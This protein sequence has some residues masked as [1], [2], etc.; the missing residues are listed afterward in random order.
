MAWKQWV[1]LDRDGKWLTHITGDERPDDKKYLGPVGIKVKFRSDI[2]AT[3]KTTVELKRGEPYS[4]RELSRNNRFRGDNMRAQSALKGTNEVSI[5]EMIALP[6]A[7]G[8]EY[9]LRAQ[10]Q[11]ATDPAKEVT[12]ST[13]IETRRALF[14]YSVVLDSSNAPKGNA[15]G[16]NVSGTIS[17]DPAVLSRFESQ[18][19]TPYRIHLQNKGEVTI[20]ATQALRSRDYVYNPADTDQVLANDGTRL[21][22]N[23]NEETC[24]ATMDDPRAAF[25]TL[26]K[27]DVKGPG[28]QRKVAGVWQGV[29]RH[30]DEWEL[31]DEAAAA[32]PHALLQELKPNCFVIVWCNY[33][34]DK[35][36]RKIIH[37][38]KVAPRSH[39]SRD[40]R[41]PSQ[42]ESKL[43]LRSNEDVYIDVGRYLWHGFDRKHDAQKR[44]LVSIKCT[45]V[46]EL[47]NPTSVTIPTSAVHP[48]SARGYKPRC[49]KR[50]F[51]GYSW[52]R[53]HLGTEDL[54]E[55]K[56]GVF[57]GTRGQFYFEVEVYVV[58]KMSC[59]FHLPGTNV[60]FVCDKADFERMTDDEKLYIVSHELGHAMGMTAQGNRPFR[61]GGRA[62]VKTPDAPTTLYG[63]RAGGKDENSYG[64]QG[65]HCHKG[66][67]WHQSWFDKKAYN[68]AGNL[69][70]RWRG[71]WDKTPECVMFGAV[72]YWDTNNKLVRAPS[73]YCSECQPIVCKLDL[74]NLVPS[75]ITD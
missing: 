61:F 2:A 49:P 19:W 37:R 66:A 10:H 20:Q 52:L 27:G 65:N 67:T 5:A 16:K 62:A 9:E 23:D 25:T 53:V 39:A 47:G 34:A 48:A 44:W 22:R 21:W 32:V 36:K 59:G 26:E 64:H 18:H 43:M 14:Y 4:A 63:N 50:D 41:L 54:K 13:S 7:G 55:V 46:D 74:S 30:T 1:N 8:Y 56:R 70:G 73:T 72:G 51:G 17:A 45:F 29:V 38:G 3:F 40:F 15:L 68:S 42:L 11:S 71:C 35:A 12:A 58:E 75:C 24:A 69:E 31:L 28:S 33:I 57:E 60:I 6:P